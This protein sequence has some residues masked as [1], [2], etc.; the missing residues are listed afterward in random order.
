VL[1]DTIDEGFTVDVVVVLLVVW[2]LPVVWVVVKE[3]G[4][5]VGV[6]A[7]KR[8]ASKERLLAVPGLSV[9]SVLGSGW[10]AASKEASV[11][12]GARRFA[13]GRNGAPAALASLWAPCGERGASDESVRSSSR[14][15][16]EACSCCCS[17]S[18]SGCCW[19]PPGEISSRPRTRGER[20]LRLRRRGVLSTAVLKKRLRNTARTDSERRA[21]RGAEAERGRRE[22]VLAPRVE[23]LALVSTALDDEVVVDAE[24]VSLAK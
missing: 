21:G 24:E 19:Q 14:S 23:V 7:G 3:A 11:A 1:T 15:T 9:E 6:V 13:A 22:D 2:E 10:R 12:G 20:V 17:P 5:V 4:V 16:Y 8:S 18:S